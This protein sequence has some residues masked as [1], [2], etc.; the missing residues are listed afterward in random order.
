M[1][2]YALNVTHKTATVEFIF[3][4]EVLLG[5]ISSDTIFYKSLEVLDELYSQR[6]KKSHGVKIFYTRYS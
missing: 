6:F 3:E 2:N 1:L 5:E 4:T